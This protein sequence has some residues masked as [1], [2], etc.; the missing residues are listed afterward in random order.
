VKEFKTVRY[1][2]TVTI[3]DE[4]RFHYREDTQLQMPGRSDL[5]HHTDENTL[6]RVTD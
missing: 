1:E 4:N 5:F 3:L 2:L 6:T